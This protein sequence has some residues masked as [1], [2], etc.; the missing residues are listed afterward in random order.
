[1]HAVRAAGQEW[2]QDEK[3]GSGVQLKEWEKPGWTYHAKGIWLRPTPDTP[4][5]LTLFGS[6]NLNSR[7][8]HID[9]ELS[10]VLA[11]TAP[12]LRAR[13]AEE[14]DGLRMHAL[15]WRGDQ[16]HVRIG[17]RLLVGAVGGML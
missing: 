6:T 9:T 11:T 17:T 3:G 7:S 14:V 5:L 2:S 12:S 8:A 4:P 16:R 13:L 15:P 10:F 1:M